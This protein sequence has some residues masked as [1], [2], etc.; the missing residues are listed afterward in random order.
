MS[1]EFRELE[2]FVVLSEELHFTRTA[3]RLFTSQARVSQLLRQLET[4]IGTRLFERNSRLVRLTPQGELFL[5]EVRP[6]YD[7]VTGAVDRARARARGVEGV[8]RVGFVGTPYGTLLDLVADFR[9]RHPHA[10][11]ELVEM[12]LS[13]P[14]GPVLRGEL[15]AAFVTLPVADAKLSTGA[16]IASDPL[17]LGVS[18]RHPFARRALVDAEDLA[19]CAFVDIA[20]PAPAS[21]R[22]LQSPT[23]TP[24]GR[25]IPRGP[26][27]STLQEALSHVAA[28]QGVLLF[29]SQFAAYNGRPDVAFVPVVGLTE[30]AVT[31]AWRTGDETNLLRSFADASGRVPVST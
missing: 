4:R 30:S 2:C 10:R 26:G 9:E 17:V 24:G 15:D 27:A 12:R 22:E 28:D 5:A 1:L 13:D 23:T 7:D 14:F 29:C 20:G 6:A 11:A 31:L 3:T 19:D 8:L 18:L 16:L 21:W 25:P